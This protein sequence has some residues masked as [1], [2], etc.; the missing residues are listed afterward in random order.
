VSEQPT[1]LIES[2]EDKARRLAEELKASRPDPF[3]STPKQ[4]QRHRAIRYQMQRHIEEG[5]G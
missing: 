2:W 1:L 3:K 4:R 5:L